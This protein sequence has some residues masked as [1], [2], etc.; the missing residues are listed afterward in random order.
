MSESIE[1]QRYLESIRT[2]YQEWW[3]FYTLT[4]A[5]GKQ[6][7]SKEVSPFFDFNLIVKT[8][9]REE[10][11]RQEEKIERFSILE[12]LRRY[13]D[14]QVLLVGRPGSGKSTALARL[15][16]EEATNPQMGIPVLVEL[17]YWQG[18]IEQLIYNSLKRHGL[19][20]ERLEAVLSR[21]LLLFDGVNELPSEEAR[22]QL[23]AFRRYHPKLPM[24]F[25]TRD[26]SL[27]G[28]LGIEKKLEM[29]PL[30]EVQMREFVRSYLS[31]EHAEKML[32]QL[33]DRL[34]EFGQT[35]LLLWMLC[36][37]IKQMPDDRL[38]S[39]L[40]GIFQ[41][42]TT[43]YEIS[44]VRRH[45]VAVLKGDVKPLSDRR[46]WKKALKALAFLMMQGKTPV[47][48]RVVIDRDE[49]ERELGRFFSTE[50]FPV[51]DILDD[52]LKYHLLQNRRAN[53]IEFRHQLIQEYYAAEA[54]L[55]QL[56]NLNDEQL[57][58]EYLNFLKWT[59]PV[60][61]MMA[62]NTNRELG[63][64]IVRLALQIDLSLGARLAGEVKQEWQ[65]EAITSLL[66]IEQSWLS[67][68]LLGI[69]KS[70]AA[71]PYLIQ[72]F[73]GCLE[74]CEDPWLCMLALNSVGE[75]DTEETTSFLLSIL[76][77]DEI[78]GFIRTSAVQ[79]LK[80]RGNSEIVSRLLKILDNILKELKSKPR[81]QPPDPEFFTWSEW[82]G[83]SSSIARAIVTTFEQHW[84]LEIKQYLINLLFASEPGSQ[85][86]AAN[87][88][89]KILNPDE[90]QS[91]IGT[92]RDSSTNVFTRSAIIHSFGK[93]QDSSIKHE[94]YELIA[95][96]DEELMLRYDAAEVFSKAESAVLLIPNLLNTLQLPGNDTSMYSR[97][98]EILIRISPV[99]A[100]TL[101]DEC[102]HRQSGLAY[103]AVGSF[104]HIQANNQPLKAILANHI[105]K[106]KKKVFDLELEPTIRGNI[107]LA[108]GQIEESKAIPILI[109]LSKDQNSVVRMRSAEALGVIG[110]ESAIPIL[111]NMVFDEIK[112]V[113]GS[114]INALGE[115]R[116]PVVA[117][118]FLEK[119]NYFLEDSLTFHA[120]VATLGKLLIPGFLSTLKILSYLD[121]SCTAL[122]SIKAIQSSSKYYNYDIYQVYLEAQ[123]HDRQIPQSS[124]RS[125]TIINNYPNVTEVKQTI[126]SNSS[127]YNFP[128]AQKV[129]IFEQVNTYIENNHPTDPEIKTAIADLTL[130]LTHL[131]TQHPQVTTESQALTVLDA[132]FTEIQQ[133]TTHPLITLRQ[134]LLNP[135]RHLQAIKATLA[136]VAKHYLEESVWSKAAIT[137]FDKLSETP[138]QGA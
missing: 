131:Q 111:M 47:D 39:N 41:S 15:M 123:K 124:D 115:F 27:G 56:Q 4:D 121:T 20:V 97:W 82:W 113:A 95:D 44:S 60:A 100:A 14:Q 63:L 108:L 50:Q 74:S 85:S 119:I 3:K 68:E 134:Q 89:V 128:N 64:W 91:I 2:T 130:L 94:L 52:L 30:S 71:L 127:K 112:D 117:D 57:K 7:R 69:T 66:E 42:F 102:F 22:S 72:Q 76:E 9:K 33:N 29:Q 80:V 107:A 61:L 114:A 48:F 106:L 129:Q 120:Y 34:R 73:N 17:R 16:L 21:L 87:V 104:I 81:C 25:T 90:V 58:R 45:E 126:M 36:E 137:Y 93:L 116:T 55:Q 10:R 86:E 101:I 65:D 136:E 37:V 32:R 5:A 78:D 12:G 62:L 28:D 103:S 98:L 19:T 67:I 99:D 35:P 13:A 46:I 133:S 135:E 49:A 26:L 83:K 92:L 24:V 51:R 118:F 125:H 109:A 8:V 79:A 53:E 11:E 54:L 6:Q 132:E 40:A 59:E 84:T 38:P 138:D 105:D 122:R 88:L 77:N 43:A 31:A 18:S 23:F 110:E 1:F 96:E 70:K 75:I